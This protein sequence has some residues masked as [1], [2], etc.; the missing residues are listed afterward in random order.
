MHFTGIFLFLNADPKQLDEVWKR[1]DALSNGEETNPIHNPA[2]KGFVA[3]NSP[4]EHHAEIGRDMLGGTLYANGSEEKNFVTPDLP[5]IELTIQESLFERADAKERREKYI[6][7]LVDILR[8][9]Y[10]TLEPHPQFVYAMPEILWSTIAESFDE[11]PADA[12]SLQDKKVNYLP[13][14]TVL[15]P[16]LVETYGQETLLSAPVWRIE[17][18]S[19]G[20]IVLISS[21]NPLVPEN[22][23]DLHD[24]LDLENPW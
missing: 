4:A 22:L 17:E 7:A 1:F 8:E 13:W 6:D 16:P 12:K 21:E 11:M 19:D 9:V 15:T 5:Y 10:F 14:L 2:H 24:Y 3:R 23:Q 20:S 18:W